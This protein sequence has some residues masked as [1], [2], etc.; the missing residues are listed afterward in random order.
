VIGCLVTAC[1][2][3]SPALG[4]EAPAT[5][6][7]LPVVYPS[8]HGFLHQT[9]YHVPYG[10]AAMYRIHAP[11]YFIEG[12]SSGGERLPAGSYRY[13]FDFAILP[14]QLGG[15]LRKADDVARIEAWDATTHERLMARNFQVSDFLPLTRRYTSKALV[16]STRGRVGHRFEP[17]VYWPGLSGVFLRRITLESLPEAAPLELEARA[18]RF[19]ATMDNAYLDRGYVLCR[20]TDGTLDHIGDAAIWTGLYAAAEAWRYKATRSPEA[21][22]R[23]ETSLAALH[24]LAMTSTRR[25]TLV[26]YVDAEGRPH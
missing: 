15:L 18:D 8:N 5:A 6:V 9:G 12:Q 10:W 2:F 17:K 20:R 23:M 13:T 1:A 26:R 7:Q 4:S 19:E 21:L 25:G 3:L 11:G 14:G 22:E 24:Q 16:F